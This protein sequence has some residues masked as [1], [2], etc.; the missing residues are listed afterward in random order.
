VYLIKDL[1]EEEIWTH[2]ETYAANG[3]TLRARATTKKGALDRV[4]LTLQIVTPPPLHA[5]IV[6]WP[7]GKDEQKALAL[8]LAQSAELTLRS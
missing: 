7:A 3:R 2:G 5:N 1:S 4:K 6:G 8:E